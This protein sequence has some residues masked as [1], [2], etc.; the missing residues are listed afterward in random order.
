MR[1]KAQ[2]PNFKFQKRSRD[3]GSKEEIPLAIEACAWEIE[4]SL[5]FERLEFEFSL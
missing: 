5:E 3:Q 1:M 2:T 4:P